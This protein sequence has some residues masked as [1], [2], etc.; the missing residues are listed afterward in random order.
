MA[1]G[2]FDLRMGKTVFIN[3][4]WHIYRFPSIDLAK[5]T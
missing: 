4:Y 3:P 1:P 2:L 5:E